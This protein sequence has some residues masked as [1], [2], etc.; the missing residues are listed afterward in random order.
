MTWQ[1]ACMCVGRFSLH[2]LSCLCV[3]FCR[4]MHRPK[5][6]ADRR[7]FNN[8][9][10]RNAGHHSSTSMTSTSSSNKDPF[11]PKPGEP[12]MAVFYQL[13]GEDTPKRRVVVDRDYTLMEFKKLFGKK[14]EYR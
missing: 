7:R 9:S 3:H 5:G 6:T 13:E 12:T 11:A 10:S 1:M 14:G 8:P 2:K 4:V